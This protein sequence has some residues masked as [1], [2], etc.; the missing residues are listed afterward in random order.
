M[1]PFSSGTLRFLSKNSPKVDPAFPDVVS[2]KDR[3]KS[4]PGGLA[5]PPEQSRRQG[6]KEHGSFQC[7]GCGA[8]RE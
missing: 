2:C 6:D 1:C 8:R 5:S 4:H 3:I 7:N